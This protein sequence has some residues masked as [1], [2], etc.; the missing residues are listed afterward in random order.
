MTD[1]GASSFLSSFVPLTQVLI[2]AFLVDAVAYLAPNA[3]ALAR[4][5]ALFTPFV[6]WWRLV[7]WLALN[8]IFADVCL[9]ALW[10]WWTARFPQDDILEGASVASGASAPASQQQQHEK[11][12]RTGVAAAAA[13]EAERTLPLAARAAPLCAAFVCGCGVAVALAVVASGDTRTQALR[14]AP[15]SDGARF[16]ADCARSGLYLSAAH[17]WL[18]YAQAFAVGAC[19]RTRAFECALTHTSSHGARMHTCM[20]PVQ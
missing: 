17:R 20:H 8:V 4:G 18:M 16:V 6:A 5:C 2:Y 7:R 1:A 12:H 3:Y 13:D 19:T 10:A 11:P 14:I 15:C 9:L